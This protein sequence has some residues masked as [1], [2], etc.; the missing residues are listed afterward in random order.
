MHPGPYDNLS[1]WDV[2]VCIGR[3]NVAAE[4]IAAGEAKT[5]A[6]RRATGDHQVLTGR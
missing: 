2:Y 1:G 5:A 6:K 4:N 3:C